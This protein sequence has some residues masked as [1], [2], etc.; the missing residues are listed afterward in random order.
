[1]RPPTS[2][3]DGIAAVGTDPADLRLGEAQPPEHV[4]GS[5]AVHPLQDGAHILGLLRHRHQ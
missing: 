2:M 4:A 5:V 1:M 3:I